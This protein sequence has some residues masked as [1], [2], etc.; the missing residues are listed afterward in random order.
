MA[1]VAATVGAIL[2]RVTGCPC[3]EL[4][5]VW[6]NAAQEACSTVLDVAA[7]ATFVAVGVALAVTVSTDIKGGLFTANI[8]VTCHRQA[9]KIRVVG[10]A[11]FVVGARIGADAVREQA[12]AR[13]TVAV[14]A[15]KLS[16]FL[17]AC[18]KLG[19][20]SSIERAALLH[21]PA[22]IACLGGALRFFVGVLLPVATET[23]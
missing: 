5:R 8:R 19:T 13:F 7:N 9:S 1:E 21:N 12:R 14:F 16:H 22:D 18:R 17:A 15:T 20:T 23:R 11:L 6:K 2:G 4:F 10:G 3:G